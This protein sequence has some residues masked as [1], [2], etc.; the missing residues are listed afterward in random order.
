MFSLKKIFVFICIFIFLLTSPT[1]LLFAANYSLVP[2]FLCELGIKFYNQGDCA[3]ALHEFNKA[4]LAH[5][6]YPLALEYIAKIKHKTGLEPTTRAGTINE[7]LDKIERQQ[8]GYLPAE[9]APAKELILER[10][11]GLAKKAIPPVVLILDESLTK[12]AQPIEIERGKNI[13]L[14]G[15][16]IQR[17]LTTQP[18]ILSVEKKGADELWVTGKQ[19]GYAYLHIW[20]E[21]GRWTTEWLGVFPK[22]EGPTYEELIR[23]EQERARNFKFRYLL[24]WFSVESGRRINSLRRSS[25]AWSHNLSLL[26]ETP[27]GNLDSTL[28]VRSL[29]TST[30]MT[31][32]TLGL[33]EG[34]YAPFK[35]FSL[36]AFD[37][38]PNFSNLVF[39]GVNLRGFMLS[40]PAFENKLDYTVFWGRE[41]GGRYGNLSPGLT[42]IK[43][44][45]LDGLNLDYSPNKVQDYEFTLVHGFGRDRQPYLNRYGYDLIS[46]WNFDKLKFN[47]EIASDSERFAHLFET[48]YNQPKIDFTTQLRNVDKNFNSITGSGYRAGELGGL[49]NLHYAPSD[50]WWINSRLDMYQ[51]RLFPAE[52]DDDRWNE[53]FSLNINYRSDIW[54]SFAVSYGINN[55]LGK[56]S[57]SRYQNPG[58]SIYK[59]FQFIK[60]ISTYLNYYHQESKNFSSPS[61]DYIN[62]RLLM[63]L[64]FSLVGEL[65]YY[66][67]KEMNWLEERYFG[68]RTEPNATEMGLDFYG[69][70]GTSP[71]Y[72]DFR[73]TFR[74]EENTVSNLSFLS[75]EDYIEG[76]SQL[77]FRPTNDFELYG[78][79][80]IR[81]VWQENPSVAKRIEASFNSGMRYLWDTGVRWEA[82]GDI[83]G[84]VFKD[85]NSDG[86]RQ[87]DEPPMEGIKLW[88]GKDKSQVT[89]LFGSYQFKGVRA[90]KAYITLDTTTIPP[91]YM[92]TVPVTQE[93]TIAQ[94][95]SVKL[96]FGV[97]VRSEI[98]G[99][100]FEDVD[101]N[102]VFSPGD[103]GVSG[104]LITLEDGS[105]SV[106]DSSGGYSFPKAAAGEHTIILDL[107]SLPVYYLPSTAIKKEVT[108]FEGVTYV[109]NIPLKRIQE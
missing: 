66:L 21:R 78:S 14:V 9:I 32:F 51:N 91:G 3:Q 55:D 17:F 33:T 29:K 47:Y 76:Y 44:S 106:T 59:R 46:N 86:L 75:G 89:D 34:I 65:Y 80:R 87:R 36:R 45:F 20:D 52:E 24:D 77:S 31:Y 41:G 83:E 104:A 7:L 53:D 107:N 11:K 88:L 103:K 58:L 26:G 102:G 13:I 60:D 2:Q 27:Y 64:R 69:Q 71:F 4:L 22:P 48:R 90:R 70:L 84:C 1:P 99:L 43:N 105:K 28:V 93:A 81:N 101:A 49:F 40:S 18:E 10:E 42:K 8:A 85:Y 23:Q 109:Y 38:A 37:Y 74:D 95:R 57:Q 82:I 5:P 16:N 92:L 54:T 63:G 79:C 35:D 72:T 62:E 73:F 96:D 12:S 98:R 19:V 108:L 30:D 15:R 56:L 100:V 39:P 50:K 61:G 68:N 97:T 94:Q 67:R 25:Y 6:G